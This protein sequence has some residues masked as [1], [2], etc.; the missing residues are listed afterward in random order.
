[1]ACHTLGCDGGAGTCT[2]GRRLAPAGE[3]RH[4]FTHFELTI[5][6]FAARVPRIDAEG[7]LRPIDALDRRGAAVGHAQVRADGDGGVIRLVIKQAL[8]RV[9]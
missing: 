5:G 7:F 9:P 3:V 2:N 4:G 6:L 8:M 1:M